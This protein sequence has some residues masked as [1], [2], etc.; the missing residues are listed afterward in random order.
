MT[1][2]KIEFFHDVILQNSIVT[3]SHQLL[4]WAVDMRFNKLLSQDEAHEEA[5]NLI[6]FNVSHRFFDTKYGFECSV[7]R[8]V[9]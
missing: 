2:S 4:F 8:H 3:L 1:I 9:S 7:V 5:E 6:F